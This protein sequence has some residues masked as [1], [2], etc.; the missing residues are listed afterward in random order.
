MH[1]AA[2]C[3]SARGG[4]LVPY[5]MDV[6]STGIALGS[7]IEVSLSIA[8]QVDLTPHNVCISLNVENADLERVSKVLLAFP[9]I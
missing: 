4:S 6:W 8:L 7:V 2:K 9:Y 1:A 5:G 3:K